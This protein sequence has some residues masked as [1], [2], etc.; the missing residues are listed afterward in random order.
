[1]RYYKRVGLQ[2]ETITVESYSHDASVGGAFEISEAEYNSFIES[3]PEL[4][5]G[6]SLEDRV[7]T[8]EDKVGHLEFLNIP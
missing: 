7:A 1:M 2:D 4:P 6:P 3:R 5:H 8:L